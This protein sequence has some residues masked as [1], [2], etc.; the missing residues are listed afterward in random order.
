MALDLQATPV[1]LRVWDDGTIRVGDTR[2]LLEI[3]V[4]A[5]LDGWSAEEIVAQY[6][7]LELP[8]VYAVLAY[9]LRHRS[10][11]DEYVRQAEQETEQSWAQMGARHSQA[12]LRE[13]L[14][15]RLDKK[16]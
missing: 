7:S 9:Y 15:A 6:D 4:R 2:V 16:K 1:P 12:G 5:Y 14:L 3:V 11:V 10:E 13:Q 8:D